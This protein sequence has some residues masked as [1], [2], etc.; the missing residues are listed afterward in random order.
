MKTASAYILYQPLTVSLYVDVIGG[1]M[2]QAQDA[3]TG[4]YD[5]DRSLVPL[6]LKPKLQIS[7]PDGILVSGDYTS[8]LIDCRWYEANDDSDEQKRITG[9][10]KGYTLGSYGQ[11][12]VSKNVPSSSPVS[13]FFT[14]A[15]IDRRN[16]NIFRKTW[17]GSLTT[18]KRLDLKLSMKLDCAQKIA[19]SPFR[20]PTA[21][22]SD[23]IR[24]INATL[25]NG[26][27][28][29][30]ES[31]THFSW[32]ILENGRFTQFNEYPF[33]DDDSGEGSQLV[34]KPAFIDKELFKVT[35]FVT[36]YPQFSVSELVKVYRD[37]G[38][39]SDEVRIESGKF[40]R[41]DTTEIT[42]KAYVTSRRGTYSNPQEYFDITHIFTTNETN[43]EEKVIGYGE[44]VTVPASIAGKDPHIVPVFGI[45]TKE[46]TA[47][48]PITIDGKVVIMDG[49][50]ACIQIPK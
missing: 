50:V 48:R 16:N 33:L 38:N 20:V 3:L 26:D 13:L 49:Y 46:R 18:E 25:Y 21:E 27:V 30:D 31:K 8:G 28:P 42:A 5:P 2:S 4:D 14:C 34:I 1:T 24:V 17:Q 41:P 44:S 6:I 19:I 43:A 10:T 12:T 11:L 7:D 39:W 45:I 47:L 36:D 35:G 32:E 29:I 22:T 40:I 15:W 23:H 9:S 37:Y